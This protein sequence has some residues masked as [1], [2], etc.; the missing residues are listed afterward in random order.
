M[1]LGPDFRKLWTASTISNLGD[2]ARVTALPLLVATVTRDP[3]LVSG[4][5]LATRLPWLLFA[6]V[7]GAIA[8]RVNRRRLMAIM[9]AIRCGLMAV[10]TIAVLGDASSLP[11]VYTIAF[12]LGAAEVLFDISAVSILPAIIERDRLEKANGRLLGAEIAANEFVGGP[13]GGLL[14]ASSRFLPFGLSA[15]AFG[16]A[17]LLVARVG[18][19]FDP[20][21]TSSA[22][23][24][25]REIREGISW[26]LHHRLIRTLAIMV[27]VMNMMWTAAFSILVLF[28]LERLGVGEVGFG[29]LIVPVALGSVIGSLLADRI[30]RP[31][32]T[33]P[34]LVMSV[35]IMGLAQ[36]GIGLTTSVAVFVAFTFTIGVA[37]MTWNVITVSLR[38]ALIPD[39]LLGRI[40]SV[41][42][43]LAWGT[44]PVGAALGGFLGST[45]GLAAPYLVGGVVAIA[46]A[47]LALPVINTRSIEHARSEAPL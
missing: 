24:V 26:L 16:A 32:G 25:W 47:I 9:Q 13:L 2:G 1:T 38:Q 34:T 44:M 46:L 7:G 20:V 4:V 35:A 28:A 23:S 31:L 43:L 21:P 18:G 40:N 14:F 11:L 19:S 36:F 3:G 29:L 41:Y 30:V 8:D 45:F 10:L 15:F 12:L 27:G 39:H 5:V 37:N 33:A 22:S 17:G 6:L 42:R